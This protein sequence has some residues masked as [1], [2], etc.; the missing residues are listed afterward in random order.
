MG[1]VVVHI[2]DCKV[3]LGYIS[4]VSYDSRHIVRAH[5]TYLLRQ[6][7]GSKPF[8]GNLYVLEGAEVRGPKCRILE[9]WPVGNSEISNKNKT[10]KMSY[11]VNCLTVFYPRF[12]LRLNFSASSTYST[13]TESCFHL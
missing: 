1:H 11:K 4:D 13:I 5:G 6:T 9:N 3:L 12:Y 10:L 2:K 8:L 7:V